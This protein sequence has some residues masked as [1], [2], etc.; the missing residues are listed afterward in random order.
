MADQEG[1]PLSAVAVGYTLAV[2][3]ALLFGLTVPASV[4]L[5][6][7]T[8]PNMLAGLLYLGA[9]LAVALPAWRARD[10]AGERL[11]W[12]MGLGGHRTARL[13]VAVIAGGLLAPVL[14]LI[15]LAASS[16]SEVSLLLNLE[17][18]ATVAIA[19]AFFH[20][21]LPWRGWVGALVLLLA[22]VV[23]AGGA[24]GSPATVGLMALA[25][26]LWALDSNISATLDMPGT[27]IVLAKGLVAGTA[28]VVLALFL[29]QPWP[30]PGVVLGALAVGA[31]GYGL[32]LV[33]WI[34]AARR[35]GTAR[36][37]SV[38]ALAPFI[39]AGAGWLLAGS[40]PPLQL[41]AAVLAAAGVAL[42]ITAGAHAHVHDH[43]DITHSHGHLP[44]SDH[45]HAHGS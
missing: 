1:L 40:L 34:D 18:A 32:S 43:G 44:D 14:V 35:L 21:H 17:L 7:H 2:L 31:L 41:L 20:D 12:R 4:P 24:V 5:I 23:L 29:G 37:T 11:P 15:A 39:G 42:V 27:R 25:C 3:A 33:S 22:G 6:E 13:L 30:T 28:N 8:G 38:F 26:I 45:R 36:T 16:A 9:A 19:V 10:D